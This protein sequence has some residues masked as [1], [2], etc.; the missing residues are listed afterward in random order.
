M[1]GTIFHI[2]DQFSRGTRLAVQQLVHNQTEHADQINVA[3]LVV[4]ANV[5]RLSYPAPMEDLIDGF[6]M[7]ADPQ[8]VPY[9]GPVAIYRQGSFQL[10]IANHQWDQLFRK[11]V[12]TIVI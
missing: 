6:N 10:D 4:A 2:R 7:V 3:H 1:A 12:R 5:I 8:P 9:I 11:L